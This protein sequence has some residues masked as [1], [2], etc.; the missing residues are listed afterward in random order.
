[1]V[2]AGLARDRFPFPSTR[3]CG[4]LKRA[5]APG[6]DGARKEMSAKLG[7][8]WVTNVKDSVG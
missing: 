5:G 4:L 8:P 7:G 1:M 2:L 3:F 6:R